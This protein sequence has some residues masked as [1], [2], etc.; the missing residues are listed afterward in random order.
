[1]HTHTH[2]VSI[3]LFLYLSFFQWYQDCFYLVLGTLVYNQVLFQKFEEFTPW[4]QFQ[5][6]GIQAWRVC[7]SFWLGGWLCIL[8]PPQ[9]NCFML[10]RAP[11]PEIFSLLYV[12]DGK[13]HSGNWFPAEFGSFPTIYPKYIQSFLFHRSQTPSSF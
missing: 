5:D 6:P 3:S 4:E 13:P 11:V 1:M 9:A 2:S 10:G 8:P 7:L 12:Q